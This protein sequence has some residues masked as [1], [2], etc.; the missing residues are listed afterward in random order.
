MESGTTNTPLHLTKVDLC[1]LQELTIPEGPEYEK[2]NN[3]ISK[4]KKVCQLHMTHKQLLR[5]LDNL[6]KRIYQVY[7]ENLILGKKKT[8]FN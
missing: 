6:E 8:W 5:S 4:D 1:F 3:T 7:R 2:N